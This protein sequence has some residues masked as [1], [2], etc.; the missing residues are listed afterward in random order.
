[1]APLANLTKIGI[2]KCLIIAHLAL[3]YIKTTHPLL[4]GYN[5]GNIIDI[6]ER[7]KMFNLKYQP[8]IAHG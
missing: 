1:M 8:Q 4:K 2:L 3:A 5:I 7:I 6:L